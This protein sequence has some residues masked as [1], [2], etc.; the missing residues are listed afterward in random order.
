[1]SS[2]TAL[3]LLHAYAF[4]LTGLC[5]LGLTCS[6]HA[7]CPV[8]IH[9]EGELI[10]ILAEGEVAGWSVHAIT[11]EGPLALGVGQPIAFKSPPAGWYVLLAH[12]DGRLCVQ[13]FPLGDAGPSPVAASTWGTIKASY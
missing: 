8:T 2:R 10:L 3:L 9:P 4:L 1:M 12:L 13:P 6:A 7:S 11:G 5:I